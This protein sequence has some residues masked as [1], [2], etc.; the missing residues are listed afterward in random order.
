M[1]G[2]MATSL[3]GK[4]NIAGKKNVPPKSSP[5]NFYA[6]FGCMIVQENANCNDPVCSAGTSASIH[7]FGDTVGL[8]IVFS[9][10]FAASTT[11]ITLI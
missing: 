5:Y 11:D 3:I 1:I 8:S 2:L 10:I 9:N 6:Q 7:S 4:K